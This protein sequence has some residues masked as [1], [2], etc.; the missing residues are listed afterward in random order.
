[1]CIR[2]RSYKTD[3]VAW[4]AVSKEDGAEAYEPSIE[5]VSAGNYPIASPLYIY[6]VGEPEGIVKEYIDWVK[7]GGQ[8]ALQKEGFVPLAK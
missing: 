2:D 8:D 3:K 4:L 7:K 5:N 6:T 1:M